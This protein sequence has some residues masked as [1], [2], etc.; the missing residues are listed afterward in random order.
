[1][2]QTS[3]EVRGSY[4][5]SLILCGEL[6]TGPPINAVTHLVTPRSGAVSSSFPHLA[7][8]SGGDQRI[9]VRARKSWPGV[10][11]HL[12][13]RGPVGRP[14]PRPCDPG[15]RGRLAA[16]GRGQRLHLQPRHLPT[17]RHRAGAVPRGPGRAGLLGVRLRR[18]GARR[19]GRPLRAGSGRTPLFWPLRLSVALRG[20]VVHVVE[21]TK[22]RDCSYLETAKAECA[23]LASPRSGSDDGG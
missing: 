11:P 19:G 9:S 1:M 15:Q 16:D 7:V 21:A 18:R 8:R 4:A 23:T 14:P 3:P 20:P 13:G 12:P 5:L 10:L 6:G 22:D 17:H 2:E